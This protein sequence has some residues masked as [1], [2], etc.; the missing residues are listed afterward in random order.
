MMTDVG[1]V[2]VIMDVE[3]K[4]AVGEADRLAELIASLEATQA[5]IADLQARSEIIRL[6]I[7]ELQSKSTELMFIHAPVSSQRLTLVRGIDAAAAELLNGLGITAFA[8]LAAL[9]P[10]DVSELGAMLGDTRRISKQGWIEQGA[11]L[12]RG[13][14]TAY[15]DRVIGGELATLA[16]APAGDLG[17]IPEADAPVEAQAERPGGAIPAPSSPA[18][19]PAQVIELATRRKLQ[20]PAS[21]RRRPA[22][23]WIALAASLLLMLGIAVKG[24]GLSDALF[25]MAGATCPDATGTTCPHLA[26]AEF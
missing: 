25:D 1:N 18:K 2:G 4:A 5:E 11:L 16:T 6:E 19:E 14:M 3:F 23:S 15:A 22:G 26:A 24:T 12:A 9:T 8:D 21:A 20:K 10:E 17:R 7:A 13:I